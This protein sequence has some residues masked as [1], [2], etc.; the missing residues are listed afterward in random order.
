MMCDVSHLDLVGRGAWPRAVLLWPKVVAQQPAHGGR[1]AGA[2]TEV[3]R[4]RHQQP[5]EDGK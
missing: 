4:A 3:V 1:V 2:A 5:A